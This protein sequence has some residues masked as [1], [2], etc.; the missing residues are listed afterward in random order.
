M[1]MHELLACPAPLQVFALIVNDSNMSHFNS[2]LSSFLE[3]TLL[4]TLLNLKFHHLTMLFISSTLCMQP[5][6]AW[7]DVWPLMNNVNSK[8]ICRADQ[9]WM[10]EMEGFIGLN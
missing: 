6:V 8:T 10:Y 7:I 2:L 4:S 9:V 3:H 1:V 5:I